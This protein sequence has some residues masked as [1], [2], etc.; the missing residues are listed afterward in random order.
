MPPINYF[1]AI[2][3]ASV[4]RKNRQGAENI[5]KIENLPAGSKCSAP[6]LFAARLMIRSAT[7][8]SGNHLLPALRDHLGEAARACKEPLI[9]QLLE[10]TG[11]S[12]S[13][14]TETELVHLHGQ[15]LGSFWAAL[16]QFGSVQELEFAAE[17][18]DLVDGVDETEDEDVDMDMD[19]GEGRG[20][21]RPYSPGSNP[22]PSHKRV[23]KHTDFSG[24]EDS[25]KMQVGSS[26][27]SKSS[28]M[29]ASQSSDHG[30]LGQDGDASADAPEQATIQIA[31][32]F[33]RHV[34][35]A[36]PPQ[37]ETHKNKPTY[38]VEFSGVSRE[39]VGRHG[40]QK[41]IKATADGEFVLY[42]LGNARYNLTGHR[43]ALLEA[44]KRFAVIKEGKPALMNEFLGQTTC[45]ALA[46][47][48]QQ[49]QAG[50]TPVD[51][52]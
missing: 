42:R 16:A 22:S 41:K 49:H 13:A 12:H 35:Q 1:D 25:S 9:K 18:D 10:P 51:E 3:D 24:F 7:V 33:L 2:T 32:A 38:L 21:K 40:L 48:L 43:P 17:D 20:D 34:L 37:H 36:C 5:N 28:S 44:K 11:A 19:G 15:S 6:Q 31:S 27:R 14:L 46:F 8:R 52:K 39:F 29:H 50:G 45:E 4:F 26:P 23:R 47:R 30:Y